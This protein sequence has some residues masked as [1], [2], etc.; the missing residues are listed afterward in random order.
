MFL[1]RI[2][3]HIRSVLWRNVTGYMHG[4]DLFNSFFARLMIMAFVIK[5]NVTVDI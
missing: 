2:M 1:F 5:Q 4:G 3:H